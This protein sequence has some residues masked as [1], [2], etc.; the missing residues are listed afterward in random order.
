MK[1]TIECNKCGCIM[2]YKAKYKQYV[3][4]YCGNTEIPEMTIHK[5]YELNNNK[6]K[7]S[8]HGIDELFNLY[9]YNK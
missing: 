6:D 1:N 3:C 9:K 8:I 7:N 2:N 4:S 5:Q